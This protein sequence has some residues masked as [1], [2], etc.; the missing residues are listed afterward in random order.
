M[1]LRFIMSNKTESAS[2]INLAVIECKTV[3]MLDYSILILLI[4][5]G[6]EIGTNYQS[7][8]THFS[9]I[10]LGVRAAHAILFRNERITGIETVCNGRHNDK[11]LTANHDEGVLPGKQWNESDLFWSDTIGV[12]KILRARDDF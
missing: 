5:S 8:R 4:D 12:E 9:K 2:I 1:T 11:S 10:T 3:S 6:E 7:I